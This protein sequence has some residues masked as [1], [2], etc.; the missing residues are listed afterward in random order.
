MKDY[1]IACRIKKQI[2]LSFY[3][4]FYS[5]FAPA[6]GSLPLPAAAGMVCA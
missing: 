1:F 5:T 3:S 4:F 6:I 2:K